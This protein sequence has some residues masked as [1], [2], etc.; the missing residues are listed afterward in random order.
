MDQMKVVILY[1]PASEYATKVEAFVHDYRVRHSSAKL[2][3]INV[4]QR[5]G[6]AMASLYDIMRFPAIM[7]MATDGTLLQLWE[8]DELPL[9]DDVAS[10]MYTT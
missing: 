2:E 1:R 4:N 5:E 3:L 9:M 7:A 6:A 10:Y 8:G